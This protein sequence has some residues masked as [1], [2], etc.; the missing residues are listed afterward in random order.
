MYDLPA[1]KLCVRLAPAVRPGTPLDKLLVRSFTR[2]TSHSNIL[3][4]PFR[5][6]CLI[7]IQPPTT[8]STKGGRV[9]CHHGRHSR[10]ESF[11]LLLFLLCDRPSSNRDEWRVQ[12]QSRYRAVDVDHS[13]EPGEGRE[14]GD[15]CLPLVCGP[16]LVVRLERGPFSKDVD[17]LFRTLDLAV[18]AERVVLRDGTHAFE[19]GFSARYELWRVV[20]ICVLDGENSDLGN[21][22]AQLRSWDGEMVGG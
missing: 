14:I 21:G 18:D 15:D 8:C 17:D 6:L 12:G 13:A 20:R 3:F 19:D 9:L 16:R 1:C 4:F 2:P 11:K 22:H 10:R 5:L 7:Q